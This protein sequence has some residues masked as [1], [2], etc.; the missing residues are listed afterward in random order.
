MTARRAARA[1]EFVRV[2]IPDS[3]GNHI[4]LAARDACLKDI[5]RLAPREIIWLGDHLD[6][7]GTFS[8]HQR[9]YTN[10]IPESYED[11]VAACNAF[12][13]RAM[14]AAPKAEHHYIEGN[15][16]A[17][18][19]RWASRLFASKEDADSL[20]EV[21]GPAAVLK[22]K[23]RG[24]KYYKRSVHYNGLSIPGAIRL[25][26]CHFVHGVSHSKHATAQHLAA[27][28]SNV[29][30][31]HTHRSQSAV[32][33]TVSSDGFGAWCPG[34]LAK[35]QPLYKHTTP[36][37]W[38]HGYGVQFVAASGRFL[39]INVPIWKGES[40]LAAVARAA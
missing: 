20:L 4:D 5:R 28:G 26:K 19:E 13:D 21:Y 24:I 12:I 30:H 6:C 3:H 16:E 23:D 2:V 9:S 37:T 31:G 18:V 39:H 38:T 34:T 27:F 8:G 15:H 10:E 11:D 36:T 32:E 22:L 29:V 40:M 33:R 1:T 25:G 35:L 14:K 7:G 17:H